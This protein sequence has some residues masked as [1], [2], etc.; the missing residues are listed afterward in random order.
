MLAVIRS[1]QRSVESA[2]PKCLKVL[3]RW[4]AVGPELGSRHRSLGDIAAI[5]GSEEQFRLHGKLMCLSSLSGEVLEKGTGIAL[6]FGNRVDTSTRMAE[7]RD[8]QN[9]PCNA[10]V[11]SVRGKVTAEARTSREG[12]KEPRQGGAKSAGENPV[13][14]SPLASKELRKVGAKSAGES[15]VALS[16]LAGE[17]LKSVKWNDY[18]EVAE[19]TANSCVDKGVDEKRVNKISRIAAAFAAGAQAA[20]AFAAAQAEPAATLA[21]AAL[22]PWSQASRKEAKRSFSPTCGEEDCVSKFEAPRVAMQRAFS[23]PGLEDDRGGKFE[24]PR[25]EK[26][27]VFSAPGLEGD[28]GGKV[29]APSGEMQRVFSAPGL[30]GHRGSRAE[31]RCSESAG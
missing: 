17:E 28:R 20:L 12:S 29:E 31:T 27:R 18:C 8:V 16:L 5:D 13:A 19:A 22:A 30:G 14:L 25:R 6:K 21:A 2:D 7:S 10:S 4:Q 26:Q 23:A 11:F 1:D 24:A 9:Q 3:D 15:P